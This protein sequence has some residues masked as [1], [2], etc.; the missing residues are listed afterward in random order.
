[1]SSRP[2]HRRRQRSWERDDRDRDRDRHSRGG[3]G[4]GGGRPRYDDGRRRSSRS[5]SPRDKERH[6]RE[7]HGAPG[8][9]SGLDRTTGNTQFDPLCVTDRREH[10]RDWEDDRRDRGE[11]ER[12]D[13]RDSK[14]S[15]G[16]DEG[17]ERNFDR[18]DRKLTARKEDSRVPPGR[19]R[20]VGDSRNRSSPTPVFSASMPEQKDEI[21]MRHS[22]EYYIY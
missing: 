22:H 1:M 11:R 14:D 2:D 6:D 17:R 18:E 19:I 21:G 4:R 12:R 9:L 16:K 7:R 8:K 3:R 5:R 15:R 20:E 13:G 10:R